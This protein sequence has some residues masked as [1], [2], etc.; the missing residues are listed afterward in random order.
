ML[1]VECRQYLTSF[2]KKNIMTT[3]PL[4]N[5]HNRSHVTKGV[6]RTLGLTFPNL[7]VYTDENNESPFLILTYDDTVGHLAE[8]LEKAPDFSKYNLA[9]GSEDRFILIQVPV[10][11]ELIQ[12]FDDSVNGSF[13]QTNILHFVNW[14]GTIKPNKQIDYIKK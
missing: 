11:E 14:C 9:V 4:I 5:T 3:T 8:R 12:K 2:L 10:N 13:E 6:M 1:I 7:A